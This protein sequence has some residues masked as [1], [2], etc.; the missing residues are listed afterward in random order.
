MANKL[1]FH[2]TRHTLHETISVG[3]LHL[4]REFA[5]VYYE[6]MEWMRQKKK[7]IFSD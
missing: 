5:L 6:T 4:S 2:F 1:L 7:D 3:T